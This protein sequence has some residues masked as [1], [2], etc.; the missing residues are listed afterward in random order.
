MTSQNSHSAS[1][2]P[3]MSSSAMSHTL[4]V[5]VWLHYNVKEMIRNWWIVSD[6][7]ACLSALCAWLNLSWCCLPSVLP[8]HYL[9]Q[10]IY[11]FTQG[12]FL[13]SLGTEERARNPRSL[14]S[15]SEIDHCTQVPAFLVCQ[16]KGFNA[17]LFFFLLT[18]LQSWSLFLSPYISS[19]LQKAEQL[20]QKKKK[21]HKAVIWWALLSIKKDNLFIVCP[22]PL[23]SAHSVVPAQVCCSW[24]EWGKLSQLKRPFFFFFVNP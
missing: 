22:L 8:Y 3:L 4:S 16:V 19:Y 10:Y 2:L 6:L 14:L 11:F 17:P 21:K 7:Q 24:T 15:S 5:A 1:A 13:S 20:Q 9:Y 23:T 18:S 12:K